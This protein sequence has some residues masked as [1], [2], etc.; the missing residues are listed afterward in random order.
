MKSRRTKESLL[1][2]MS[3]AGGNVLNALHGTA[4]A[5]LKAVAVAL[6]PQAA[7]FQ[8]LPARRAEFEL[9]GRIG[10]IASQ[11]GSTL[12]TCV[13]AAGPF[14]SPRFCHTTIYSCGTGDARTCCAAVSPLPV[15]SRH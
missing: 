15:G 13:F 9:G 10:T 11:H 3:V 5:T 7:A 14:D 6:Q 2:V 8:S 4:S 12:L 1:F